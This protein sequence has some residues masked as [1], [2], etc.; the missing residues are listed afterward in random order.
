MNVMGLFPPLAL[1]RSGSTGISVKQK[2]Q[3]VTP[4]PRQLEY[5]FDNDC[6]ILLRFEKYKPLFGASY[7][8][9]KNKKP[10]M[11][12]IEGSLNRESL[13]EICNV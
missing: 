5:C 9:P 6:I 13:K 2:S 7:S 1:T 3:P 4:A 10:S 11:K 8:N 12:F